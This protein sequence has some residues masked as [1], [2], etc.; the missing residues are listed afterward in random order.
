MNKRVNLIISLVALLLAI[1]ILM[2]MV[3]AENLQAQSVLQDKVYYV[4]LILMGVF[5]GISLFNYLKSSAKVSGHAQGWG[6]EVGGPAAL[7]LLVVLGGFLLIPRLE[8]FDLTVR[9]TDEKGNIAYS[10]RKAQFTI[11]LPTGQRTGYFTAEG[12]GTIKGLPAKLFNTKAK[13]Q[14]NIYFYEQLEPGREYTLDN[15]V[16]EIQVKSNAN[17]TPESILN[18]RS[19]KRDGGI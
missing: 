2:L 18:R 8:Y 4:C 9:A 13:I 17:G 6:M 14:V 12:E 7:A 5:S 11:M 16:V 10:N 3:F 19:L 1:S 15:D